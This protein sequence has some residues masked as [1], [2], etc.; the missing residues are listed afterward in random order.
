MYP[1]IFA[2]GDRHILLTFAP[3]IYISNWKSIHVF[4]PTAR[5]TIT[6]TTTTTILF[7]P[8]KKPP[9][10]P[11]IATKPFIPNRK[12]QTR[13]GQSE[14]KISTPLPISISPTL[15]PPSPRVP[16]PLAQI[17]ETKHMSNSHA[18]LT[19]GEIHAHNPAPDQG[20]KEREKARS[21]I[22]I[23]PLFL[24]KPSHKITKQITK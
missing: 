20:G 18:S 10:H 8:Y 19:R 4:M 15:S 2:R 11:T 12:S 7:V 3:S 23:C 9:Q 13:T 21:M 17:K 6:T 22:V 24:E 16:S 14:A 1:P 5:S